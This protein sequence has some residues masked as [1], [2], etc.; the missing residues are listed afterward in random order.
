MSTDLAELLGTAVGISLLFPKLPLV[1]A[2][3]LTS[4]D[5]VV[6]MLIGDPGGAQGRPQKAFETF[7]IVLV[8]D[9][10]PLILLELTGTFTGCQ[11]IIVF[12]CFFILLV[13]VKPEWSEVFLGYVPNSALINPNGL[14]ICMSPFFQVD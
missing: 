3:M 9:V 8:R 11:V 2:V 14:F 10:Q 7:I 1:T 4:L 13:K 5:V 6:I 12:I